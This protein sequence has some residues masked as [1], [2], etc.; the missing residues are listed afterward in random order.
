MEQVAP[1]AVGSTFMALDKRTCP[2]LHPDHLC[3]VA[4]AAACLQMEQVAPDAVGS[5]F[6]ALDKH[7]NALT[8]TCMLI[9]CC[10]L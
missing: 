6:M 10:C 1:D 9:V 2:Y 7:A 5:T 3:L 4:A 8:H